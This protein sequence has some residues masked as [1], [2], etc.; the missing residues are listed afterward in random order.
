MGTN[1]PIVKDFMSKFLHIGERLREER[2]RLEKNQEEFAAFGGVGR[3]TQ[4]NYESGERA[5]DGAYL[6]G[7]SQLGADVA[8]ILT[9]QRSST[10]STLPPR[11]T[12][13]IDNYAHS[14]E[15]GKRHIESAALFAAE[16]QKAQRKR[17][18]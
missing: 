17:H 7:I 4:F 5:P 11:V 2:E 10:A 13:L 9:G 16:R 12:A 18:G 3:K 8:Y 15:E 14:D 6:A 1:L